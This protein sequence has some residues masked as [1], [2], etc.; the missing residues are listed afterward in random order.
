MSE[1]ATRLNKYISESGICSR[2]EADRYIEQ[3]NVFINGKRAKIG[4]G[5]EFGDKVKVNGHDI[6]PRDEAD[7]VF[8]ALNKPVGIVSTTENSERDNIVD[9]VNHSERVFPIGRLDKDS[10]GLIFLTS[11]G[12]LVNKILR[13]GNNHDKEYVVTV[14]KP[15]TEAFLQGMRAGV[16]MLG[17]ITKKCK[18]EQVSTF[19]FK[20]ILVQGL[21]RQIRRMCEHFNFEVT[22]LERQSIMN[23][24]LKGLPVGEWRDLDEQELSTLM[25]LIEHSSSEVKNAPKKAKKKPTQS[26]RDKIEGPEHFMQNRGAK[27]KKPTA[28]KGKVSHSRKPK[29]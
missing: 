2:R 12:D 17:V 24:S 26:L 29:R 23:V 7:L 3:G 18:V 13:A 14:N 20:I 25:K 9:F 19:V 22:K 5:V 11:N 6:A 10:Q 1:S 15:I 21:N 8:I 16:P 4:D 28:N 27:P